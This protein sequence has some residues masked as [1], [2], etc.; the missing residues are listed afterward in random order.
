MFQ[1]KDLEK[2]LNYLGH[3][4]DVYVHKWKTNERQQKKPVIDGIRN[5]KKKIKNKKFRIP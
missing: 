3:S 5:K 2:N 1:S 4:T